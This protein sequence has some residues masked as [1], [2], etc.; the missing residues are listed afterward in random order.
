[1][2]KGLFELPDKAYGI[3]L[4]DTKENNSGMPY[5]ELQVVVPMKQEFE[6]HTLGYL[7]PIR[8]YGFQVSRT[9]DGDG[10]RGSSI[11]VGLGN[12]QILDKK[13]DVYR[14][15]FYT[16]NLEYATPTT[17]NQLTVRSY[18]YYL[19]ALEAI[20]HCCSQYSIAP[21]FNF[22]LH[23]FMEGS[24]GYQLKEFAYKVAM[25]VDSYKQED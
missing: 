16:S 20:L 24:S 9:V 18:M 4:G 8:G 13:P 21:V 25:W 10:N 11:P 1:M 12:L 15:S 5:M 22:G 19:M 7:M 2:I 3:L 14:N 17:D 6:K 23:P